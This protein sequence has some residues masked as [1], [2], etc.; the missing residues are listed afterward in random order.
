MSHITVTTCRFC[1]ADLSD[2]VLDLHEQ[3]PSNAYVKPGEAALERR[4]PLHLLLCRD[5]RLAQLNATVPPDAI[6]NAD[7]AY[8]S[9]Y[10]DS[11]VEHARRYCRDAI[12]RWGLGPNSQVVEAASNDGYLLQHFVAA[13]V[14]SLGV[15]PSASVAAAAA[16]RGVPT[17]VAF[18][19]RDTARRL[20]AAGKAADLAAANNVLAHVPD[21]N[22]FV[23]G[24]AELLKPEGVL[25][26]EFP[27]LLRLLE[28]TQFDT[29]YHEHYFY[30]SLATATR[31]FA[32]HG[33]VVFDVEELPTHGGSL[34]V[35]AGRSDGPARPES[36]GLRR[37]RDA[38]AAAAIDA[39]PIYQAFARRAQEMI[40][41]T[42]G[43][44]D[45][46]KAAG[47][48][49]AGYGAAAKGNTL[50]NAVG[51]DPADLLF[52]ADR[53]PHKQGLLLPG[54]HIPVASPERIF[55]A[56]PDYVLILPWNLRAEIVAAL[57]P[58][59]DWGGR[60]VVAAP[61]LEIF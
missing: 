27:H 26:V 28:E 14:P 19:G 57:A 6:F 17:E 22:D 16:A 33:L 2:D 56:K 5:C 49:V 51:A 59:R 43:F 9:S 50:L 35:W 46:A 30:Y 54:S 37:V 52:V 12:E 44:L 20:A 13:G 4:Y 15:E 42:R 3:P 40:R 1:G 32:R 58:I 8:F 25:S 23:G 45:E 29:I 53:N 60:F 10:A 24:F 36:D 61:R 41:A 18:F 7:Y 47:R 34:R 31:V 48:T 11:W 39:A 38:E 55:E 21:V